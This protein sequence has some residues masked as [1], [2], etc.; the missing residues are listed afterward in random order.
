KAKR[1]KTTAERA[2]P[3]DPIEIDFDPFTEFTV[4]AASY[5]PI[6][7]GEASVACPFDGVQY[8]P[9]YKGTVCKVCEVCEVGGR[10]SGLRL[11]V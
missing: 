10:G 11:V 4:C 5:T 2:G 1:I 8:Q 7:A 3:T 9:Q 6:Y